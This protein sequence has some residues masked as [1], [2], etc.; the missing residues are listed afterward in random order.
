MY[1][2]FKKSLHVSMNIGLLPSINGF[3]NNVSMYLNVHIALADPPLKSFVYIPRRRVT[4][5]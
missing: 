4:G 5:S 1:M 3:V 2:T